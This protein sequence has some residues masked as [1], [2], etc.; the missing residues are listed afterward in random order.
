MN[1]EKDLEAISPSKVEL[2]IPSML[3]GNMDQALR[4]IEPL[5]ARAGAAI[6]YPEDDITVP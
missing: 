5:D 1:K 4:I 3:V 6:D 2:H